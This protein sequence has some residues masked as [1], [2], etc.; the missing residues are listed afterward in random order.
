MTFKCDNLSLGLLVFAAFLSILTGYNDAMKQ[1][2][3]FIYGLSLILFIIAL[4]MMYM[5]SQENFTETASTRVLMKGNDK[6]GYETDA[7]NLLPSIEEKFIQPIDMKITDMPPTDM[8]LTDM[9]PT[10][11][12]PAGID[13][14]EDLRRLAGQTPP[15]KTSGVPTLPRNGIPPEG[16]PD[17]LEI[18]QLGE[19]NTNSN[20]NDYMF[21]VE[22]QEQKLP[23][24][25]EYQDVGDVTPLTTMTQVGVNETVG[26][27]ETVGTVGTVVT[28]ETVGTVVT[29][30]TV[31]TDETVIWPRF[32]RALTNKRTRGQGD[33]IRGDLAITP[34]PCG[35]FRPSARPGSDLRQGALNVIAG[36][37]NEQGREL[38][39]L[40]NRATATNTIGGTIVEGLPYNVSQ[41]Q[42]VFA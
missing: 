37:N 1:Q 22:S 36:E 19:G 14:T 40:V 32:I 12:M 25:P 29:D 3:N 4:V 24:S 16:L 35:W 17:G 23:T 20:E 26:T 31:G 39:K 21:G 15:I 2:C 8:Q 38:T 33:P 41:E 34:E 28:D 6:K 27:D 7:V 13:P 11:K 42:S 9:P 18:V 5:N 10:G 30:E